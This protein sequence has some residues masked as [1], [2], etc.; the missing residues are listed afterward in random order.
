MLAAAEWIKEKYEI[1]KGVMTGTFGWVRE[2]SRLILVGGSPKNVETS[3]LFQHFKVES[4]LH[5]TLFGYAYL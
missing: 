2:V 3:I 4:I 1:G 5:N